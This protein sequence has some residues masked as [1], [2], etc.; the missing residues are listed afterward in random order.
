MIVVGVD[1]STGARAA[2]RWALDDAVRTGCPVVAVRV[3]PGGTAARRDAERDAVEREV[4]EALLDYERPPAFEV[5]LV[6]GD[7]ATALLDVARRREAERVVVGH[8]G[9]GAVASVLFGSVSRRCVT[10][11]DRTVVLVPPS[12]RPTTGRVVAGIDD[13]SVDAA[14]WAAREAALRCAR[15]V[16]VHAY[17]GIAWGNDT[18]VEALARETLDTVLDKAEV[19][20]ADR[21][22]V[23]DSVL[24]VLLRAAAHADLLVVGGP[25]RGLLTTPVDVPVAVVREPGT[26]S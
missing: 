7:P 15:L 21:V 3:W 1:G 6:E 22:V 18:A 8:R 11:A 4:S 10:V 13:D 14:R 24:P 20:D 2:L 16:A 19:R 26:R 12:P 23:E 25:L 9:L 17:D 5:E